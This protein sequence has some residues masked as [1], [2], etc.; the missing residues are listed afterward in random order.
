MQGKHSPCYHFSAF[1]TSTVLLSCLCVACREAGLNLEL[2]DVAVQSLVP[3]P[4]QHVESAADFMQQLPQY[5]ADLAR[6]V[7]DADAAGECLRFVG[8]SLIPDPPPSSSLD[9]PP[10]P[11]IHAQVAATPFCSL[12][13]IGSCCSVSRQVPC[14]RQGCT[15]SALVLCSVTTSCPAVIL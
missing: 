7:S 4:L 15:N 9:S 8:K 14:Q 10:H 6:Q 12:F 3:E 13:C 11:Y 1:H 2:S 5:D